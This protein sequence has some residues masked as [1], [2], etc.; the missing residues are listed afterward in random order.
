MAFE[1][2]AAE[3]FRVGQLYRRKAHWIAD[4]LKTFAI[5]DADRMAIGFRALD[6][7]ERGETVS[8]ELLGELAAEYMG[9]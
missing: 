1:G 5:S 4:V 3:D 6:A 2:S 9:E 8:R 7:F